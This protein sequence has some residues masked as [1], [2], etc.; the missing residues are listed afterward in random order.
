MFIFGFK[1]SE[2]SHGT[3]IFVISVR[4]YTGFRNTRPNPWAGRL[5]RGLQRFQRVYGD[6]QPIGDTAD[7]LRYLLG[8]RV[9]SDAHVARRNSYMRKRSIV[10]VVP[11]GEPEQHVGAK[12]W[13]HGALRVL[14][15]HSQRV[16]L[17]APGIVPRWLYSGPPSPP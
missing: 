6:L 15:G 13:I 11:V 17:R 12:C 14:A 4:N 3:T 5:F 1:R 10:G 8:S 9:D 2:I 7:S 16:R